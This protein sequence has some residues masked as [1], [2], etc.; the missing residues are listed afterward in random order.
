MHNS[1]KADCNLRLKMKRMKQPID[2]LALLHGNT[3]AVT[4]SIAVGRAAS[5]TLDQSNN[6]QHDV[7]VD[8][9]TECW[10][11]AVTQSFRDM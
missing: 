4:I 6:G 5:C 9:S 1:T 2:G 8:A 3:C 7:G 11:Y 10:D